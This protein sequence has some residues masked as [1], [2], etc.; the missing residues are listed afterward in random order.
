MVAAV[1][2]QVGA[3]LT[4]VIVSVLVASAALNGVAPPVLLMA[5]K[6]RFAPIV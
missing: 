1:I 2:V 6:L 3:S 4:A 5:N